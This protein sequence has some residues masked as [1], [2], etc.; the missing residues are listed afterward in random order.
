[1][2]AYV[3]VNEFSI[4]I[5]NGVIV[6]VLNTTQIVILLIY[7]LLIDEFIT[8]KTRKVQFCFLFT[9]LYLAILTNTSLLGG[10]S[11]TMFSWLINCFIIVAIV[12]LQHDL[13]IK[14]QL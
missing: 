14:F 9:N 2:L 1:M 10:F 12:L 13:S 4:L 5:G 8:K 6:S 11:L 3:I 7:N